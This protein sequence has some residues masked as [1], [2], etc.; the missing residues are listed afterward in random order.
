MISSKVCGGASLEDLTL[1][2][3][4]VGNSSMGRRDQ[5]TMLGNTKELASSLV[6]MKIS[7]E[8]LL[9]KEATASQGKDA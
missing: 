4:N 9:M 6:E 8:D 2:R 1:D 5:A 3:S 7:S